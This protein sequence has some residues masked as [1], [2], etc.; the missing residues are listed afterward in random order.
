MKLALDAGCIANVLDPRTP[1]DGLMYIKDLFNELNDVAA[2]TSF[3]EVM[4]GLVAERL[5]G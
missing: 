3:L 1:F 2:K 5:S 4:L